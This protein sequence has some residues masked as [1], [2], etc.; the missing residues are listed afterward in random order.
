MGQGE[1]KFKGSFAFGYLDE[2]P[3]LVTNIS[4][5]EQDDYL[6][7]NPQGYGLNKYRRHRDSG[8]YDQSLQVDLNYIDNTYYSTG[9]TITI[10]TPDYQQQQ[11]QVEIEENN[12]AQI[13]FADVLEGSADKSLRQVYLSNR[14]I[15][16]LSPNIG[17]LTMIRKLDLSSNHLTELPESIG[18]MQ[19]LET[20]SISKNKLKSLPDTIGYLSN[21]LELDISFNQLQ[22]L[23]PCI[24]YLEKLKILSLAYNQL[25]YLPNHISGLSS[26]ISLDLTRNPLKVLPAEISKLP[27]LR[28][29]RLEDCP[30]KTDL[31]YSLKHDPPTLLE[32]CARNIRK[33]SMNQQNLPLHLSNYI[34]SAKSCTSCHGPYYESFVLRGRLME[35]TDMHIPLEY[36]LCSAHW[37][38]ADDRILSMFSTQPSTTTQVVHQPYRPKLPCPPKSFDPLSTITRKRHQLTTVDNQLVPAKS[39]QNHQSRLNNLTAKFKKPW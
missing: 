27:Y 37:S 21:L 19:N 11:Q 12:Q 39:N 1:S 31:V 23:T 9:T 30:F 17:M 3:A 10:T 28:R 13:S 29:I 33:S 15:H 36:T 6:L 18:Y 32:I 22:E 2:S 35:K 5:E 16:R 8:Y 34:Q 24:S 25:E 14:S 38:D 26:L 7:Q 4:S 20:L